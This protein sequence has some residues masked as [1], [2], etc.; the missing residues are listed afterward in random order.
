MN[1]QADTTAAEDVEEI[2]YAAPDAAD[3]RRVRVDTRRLLKGMFVV[4]LDRPWSDTPLPRSG[5]S[6]E[7][8]EELQAIRSHCQF[9]MVDPT[10]SPEELVA[11]IHAAAKL[12]GDR[13]LSGEE[14]LWDGRAARRDGD[15]AP[16]SARRRTATPAAAPKPR[17]DVRPS[18]AARARVLRLVR[19]GEQA[20]ATERGPLSQVR[21]WLGLGRSSQSGD[22]PDTEVARHRQALQALCDQ[23]GD[24]IGACDYGAGAPIRDALPLAR[25][26]HARLAAVADMAIRQVRQ[27][28]ALAFEPMAEAADAF[29]ASLAAAPDAMRWLDA[30]HADNAPTPNPALGVA[31]RLGEFGRALGMPHDS[32]RELVLIGLLADVGKALLPRE[33]LDHPGVLKPS[34]YALVQQHVTIGLDILSRSASVPEPVLRGV[35]EHHERLDGSG[36]PRA[37]RADAIGLYGRMA[38]IVDT[39]CALTAARAYANPLSAENALSA[40]DEWSGALFCR[41]LVEQFILVNGAFPVG[42]LVELQ[43]GEVAAVVER[44][45]G[46]RLQPK[47]VVMTGPDKG[48]A[49]ARR[50][51]Q[52]ADRGPVGRRSPVRIARGLPAGA[53][54]LR[55]RDYYAMPT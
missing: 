30:V 20:P 45:P 54:G 11:A 3:E 35:A 50:A 49:R 9:V 51:P 22:S 37:L 32:L 12:S 46:S 7:T 34:D 21:R 44:Q 48:P 39:F 18:E 47:L 14:D 13:V 23:W 33:L 43:S 5:L 40:L 28:T 24:A 38:A 25:P 4:E 42:S 36:Y 31:L 55:L 52:Q 1:M 6:I 29:A 16:G 15:A 10:R 41:R 27:A 26:V 17:D 19:E 53:F 2:V 8:D